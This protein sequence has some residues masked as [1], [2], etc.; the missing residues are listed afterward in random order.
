ML[1]VI[2]S[3]DNLMVH[4]PSTRDSLAQSAACLVEYEAV[5]L[6]TEHIGLA[7]RMS[8][9]HFRGNETISPEGIEE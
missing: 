8:S 2:L 5:N 9:N 6:P 3:R 7:I 1:K 4:A